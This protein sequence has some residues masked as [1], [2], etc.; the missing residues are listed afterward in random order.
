MKV[1]KIVR[2][3]VSKYF[4]KNI[5]KIVVEKF[6]HFPQPINRIRPVEMNMSVRDLFH[7]NHVAMSMEFKG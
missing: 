2:N 4:K 1:L 6:A 3:V 5:L 7:Q